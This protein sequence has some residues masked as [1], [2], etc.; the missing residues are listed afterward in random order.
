MSV[1]QMVFDH[2]IWSQLC[3]R[4]LSNGQ[5]KLLF[6][7]LFERGNETQLMISFYYE[8]AKEIWATLVR[9]LCSSRAVKRFSYLTLLLDYLLFYKVTNLFKL[10][11]SK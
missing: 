3:F 7:L 8:N 6:N 2:K 5:K 11:K 4:H 1:G 10:H 9:P